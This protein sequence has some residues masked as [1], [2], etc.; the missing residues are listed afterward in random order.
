[1]PAL[2]WALCPD[3]ELRWFHGP[4]PVAIP[5]TCQQASV[6]SH[7]GHCDRC[8]PY[9]FGQLGREVAGIPWLLSPHSSWS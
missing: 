8:V 5:G 3:A 2:L 1:M 4:S 6:C 9:S 7:S